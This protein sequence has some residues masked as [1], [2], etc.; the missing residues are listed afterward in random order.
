[1]PEEQSQQPEPVNSDAQSASSPS[2]VEASAPANGAPEPTEETSA[3]K[4]Q[5]TPA[6]S[7]ADIAQEV[8]SPPLAPDSAPSLQ[9]SE[10]PASGPEQIARLFWQLW[11]WLRPILTKSI[12]WVLRLIVRL[13]EWIVARLESSLAPGSETP[14]S[15]TPTVADPWLDKS[16]GSTAAAAEPA[17]SRK[18][19]ATPEPS[20][21]VSENTAAS[22]PAPDAAASN[23]DEK[24]VK[25]PGGFQGLWDWLLKQVRDRI[26]AP[27]NQRLS[28]TTLSVGLVSLPLVLFWLIFTLFS[29]QPVEVAHQPR[30]TESPTATAPAPTSPPTVTAPAP[31][32]SSAKPST[33][34]P[35]TLS[36]KSPAALPAE[37]QPAASPV[38]SAS[39]APVSEP[40]AVPSPPAVAPPIEESLIG[41]IQERVNAIANSYSD[42]LIQ[43]IQANFQGSRLIVKLNPQWYTLGPTN[44]DKLANE[45]FQR[46][47]E[48]DF[49]KLEIADTEGSQLAR[50]PVVGSAMVILKRQSIPTQSNQD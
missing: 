17:A 47:Q 26:P 43:S 3:E 6:P 40:D 46:A 31:A 39:V 18:S 2:E 24:P 22:P 30:P 4:A 32:R 42:G 16:Q 14:D 13:L 7:S 11:S 45:M 34:P 15:P 28:D 50:S 37:S 1:M 23:L 27:L 5:N 21:P 10:R 29:G 8:D 20:S 48:L 25:A 19:A 12:V 33:E 35:A 36:D 38:P 49:S 44:Q 41:V 9:R